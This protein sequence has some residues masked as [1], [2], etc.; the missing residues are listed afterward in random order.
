MP[1]RAALVLVAL[2]SLSVGGGEEE[3]IEAA[4][5][6][7]RALT[8]EAAELERQGRVEEARALGARI[9]H[10]REILDGL[11][12][13]IEALQRL[14]R[15]EEARQLRRILAEFRDDGDR[16]Y[17]GRV[18]SLFDFVLGRDDP[19]AEARRQQRVLRWAV[20]IL[21]ERERIDAAEL[22]ERAMHALRLR[23]E[24]RDDPEARRIQAGAPGRDNLA[25]ALLLA[26]RLLR[27][28][29]RLEKAEAVEEVVRSLLGKR[30]PHRERDLRRE[31]ILRRLHELEAQVGQLEREIALLRHELERRAR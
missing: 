28:S 11:E 19:G 24:G 6:R 8:S 18:E 17:K 30:R 3:K 4:R 31:R 7:Y 13:G 1:V 26:E 9:E 23:I 27:E 15:H 12:R 29:D 25:E 2:A 20:E 10:R 22:V 16:E 5:A 21:V 14:G